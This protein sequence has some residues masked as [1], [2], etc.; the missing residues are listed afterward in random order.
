MLIAFLVGF[1]CGCALLLGILY[2]FI[3]DPWAPPTN[4]QQPPIEQFRPVQIP[5][6]LRGFLKS[7]EDGQ[8]ISRW[9]SCN[10]IS[11]LLHMLFQEHKDTRALRRWVHKRLQME[12][13]DIT[14][15]SAAGRL[16]QEIRIRELSLGTKFM[17]INSIRVENVEMAEDKNTFEKIVF[18][19]DIDYSG[20]FETSIDVSTIITKK[21]SLS[22]K[23]TKLTGMVRVI[24]SRQPYHHWTFSFVTQ[25]VFETDINSQIQ[26]HQLKRLIPIIKEAIRRSL[27]RKHV[28]PNYK[29]RYRPFF[30]NP[31]FQASPPINSFTHIKMEGGMEVTVLQ[32]SRLKNAL[33]EDKTKNYEIYCTVSIESRPIVQNEEQGHVVNVLLTF[34][35]YDVASPIGLVFDKSVQTTGV[36]ANRA[37]KVCTVEDNSLADKAAF[38]PGD[39]LVAINNVPIRSER[40]ATRFLQSTTG[41]LTVLVER[42]LDDID[43]EESKEAEIIVSTVRDL[44]GAVLGG[45]ADT[46]SLMS[47]ASVT[48]SENQRDSMS[49]KTEVTL[50]AT[51][52]DASALAARRRHSVSNFE[53]SVVDTNT[54]SVASSIFGLGMF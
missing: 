7:G 40:Q 48:T 6:E 34:S 47:T 33:L 26:G 52:S 8:G 25:P 38:K 46:T 51:K 43:D 17:T 20:G 3:V 35:R 32:C 9:E 44:D 18:I 30:P 42:S 39:V 5:E 11:L 4:Q 10:S 16:I 21:A 13:N 1:L 50:R 22:V 45:D 37:V 2:I 36:N 31:I 24:L 49:E 14:T 41:D 19:L 54:E 53:S 23:I 29:I 27:Q 28:W 15:R 12:L